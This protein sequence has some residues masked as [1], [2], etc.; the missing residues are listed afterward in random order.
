MVACNISNG[1]RK[2]ITQ[3]YDLGNREYIHPKV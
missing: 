2:R 3:K 1:N